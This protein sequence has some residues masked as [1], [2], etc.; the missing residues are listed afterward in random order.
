M[1][2]AS[3]PYNQMVYINGTGISG[4]QSIDGNYGVTEQNVSFVGWAM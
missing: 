2:N 4:I 3:L 1:K